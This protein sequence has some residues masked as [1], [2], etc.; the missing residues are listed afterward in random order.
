MIK[1]KL[2][3]ARG[4]SLISLVIATLVIT[5]LADV[6]IYNVRDNLKLGKLIEMENDIVNLRDKVSAYYAQNGEIPATIKYTNIGPIQ[7]AGLISEAVDTGDFLVIDLSALENLTLN[8]GKDFEKVKQN[9]QNANSY[10]DL[11]IINK[12]SHNVFYVAGITVDD[13]TFYTDYKSDD[14]DTATVDLRY[15][16]NVKIPDGFYYLSGS[17]ENADFMIKSNDD[18]EQYIWVQQSDF[19]TEVPSGINL[20]TNEK[21]DFLKS[22][23]SY[24]GYYRNMASD[25]VIYQPLGNW[26]LTYDKEGIYK[27]KNGHTAY[28]PQGFR[29][30]ETPGENTVDDGLVVKDSNDNEWV[31]IEVPHTI[32]TTADS[33]EDYEKIEKDMQSYVSDYR[34]ENYSDIWYAEA[35]HGFTNANEYNN[36]KKNML[37]SVYERGGF[38]IGRYEVGT[39]TARTSAS[40]TETTPIIQQ[41]AY[42]YHFIT[43]K[44]AQTL[45][46]NLATPQGGT[47]SLMFGIQ[48]DLVLKYLEVKEAKTKAELRTDSA[49]WGNYPDATFDVVRGKYTTIPTTANSWLTVNNSYAKPSSS[50]LFSTGATNRNSVSNIFDLAGNVWEWTLEGT[51]DSNLPCATRGGCYYDNVVSASSYGATGMNV[52]IDT[53]GFR[54][55]FY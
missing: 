12:T 24:Q 23:N 45:A 29:V 26:S 8:R 42:P 35:Q 48:W 40:A 49:T 9:P 27:D 41:G 1:D 22:V 11:Y 31:W 17:K 51:T 20:P 50:V 43:C 7:S 33:S 5:I 46:K 55:A 52:A 15:V 38:Y 3:S 19:I 2:K 10:T 54:P 44:Q 47:T 6:I 53:V 34:D 16:E 32:Y 21:E 14:I 36:W 25:K 30:S 4:I 28:I 37:K 18:T 39:A 13:E